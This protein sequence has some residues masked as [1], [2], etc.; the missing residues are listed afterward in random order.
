MRKALVWM[1]AAAV[2]TAGCAEDPGFLTV[3]G[4][5]IEVP[6]LDAVYFPEA[7]AE[8]IPPGVTAG[9]GLSCEL[10]LDFNE[11]VLPAWDAYREGGAIEDYYRASR[12]AWNDYMEVPGW[13]VG[14]YPQ[15]PEVGPASI[16]TRAVITRVLPAEGDLLPVT[17]EQVTGEHQ[18]DGGTV[19]EVDTRFTA[20]LDFSF[21]TGVEDDG[22]WIVEQ[23]TI[24]V[25]APVC[26]R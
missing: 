18:L 19:D 5:T 22:T 15:E 14:L 4:P 11:L 17:S 26:E 8:G 13:A 16:A 2:G 20:T 7:L 10:L 24:D 1:A 23:A 21:Q 3:E 9:V 12:E 6:P 25:D